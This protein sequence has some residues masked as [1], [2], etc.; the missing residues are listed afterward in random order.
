MLGY[1][2]AESGLPNLKP[3]GFITDMVAA[4]G[5]FSQCRCTGDHDHQT[6]EG[7]NKFGRRSLQAAVWPAELDYFILLIICSRS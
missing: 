5:I 1:H 6:L 7:S 3:M 4:V 2:N